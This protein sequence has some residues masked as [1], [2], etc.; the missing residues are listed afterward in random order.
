MADMGGYGTA[1]ERGVTA[2]SL[3]SREKI[4]AFTEGNEAFARQIVGEFLRITPPLLED[5]KK[6]LEENNVES[7]KG[8]CHRIKGNLAYLGEDRIINIVSEIDCNS[9]T[10]EELGPFF[11]EMGE[12]L[13]RLAKDWDLPT[14][15]VR[16]LHSD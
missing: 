4:L 16:P 3:T 13:H 6:A 7:L 12:M 8:Y 5:I 2:P 15:S 11:V 9:V 1:A 14:P 10:S